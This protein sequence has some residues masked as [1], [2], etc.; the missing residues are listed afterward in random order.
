MRERGKAE[1][2]SQVLVWVIRE[3]GIAASREW[4]AGRRKMECLVCS[5][6]GSVGFFPFFSFFFLA[7]ALETYFLLYILPGYQAQAELN[8][9]DGVSALSELSV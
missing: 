9:P 4:F 7:W 2:D 1:G 3:S 6:K 5:V 8:E